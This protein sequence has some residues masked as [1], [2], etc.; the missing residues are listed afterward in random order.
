MSDIPKIVDYEPLFKFIDKFN[1][2]LRNSIRVVDPKVNEIYLNI[3]QTPDATLGYH[4]SKAI[5]EYKSSRNNP[6]K[7]SEAAKNA[8]YWIDELI[9][10]G[11]IKEGT[12]NLKKLHEFESK[13]ICLDNQLREL[14]PKFEQCKRERDDFDTQLKIAKTEIEKLKIQI[15]GK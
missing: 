11:L 1:K 10:R 4:F 15:E 9:N 13:S 2:D 12:E 6:T 3:A 14:G 5:R 8:I 7:Q